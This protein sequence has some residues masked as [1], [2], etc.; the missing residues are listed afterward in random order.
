MSLQSVAACYS[1]GSE[2][3]VHGRGCDVVLLCVELHKQNSQEES[4][5]IAEYHGCVWWERWWVG[6]SLDEVSLAAWVCVVVWVC[7]RMVWDQVWLKSLAWVW[8]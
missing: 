5:D 3:L 7:G 6:T 2:K 8:I 1:S 4:E